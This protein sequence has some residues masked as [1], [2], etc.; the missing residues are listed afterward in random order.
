MTVLPAPR[1][2]FPL[3]QVSVNLVPTRYVSAFLGST[4]ETDEWRFG[5][6]HWRTNRKFCL[7]KRISPPY[8]LV[9]ILLLYFK[10]KLSKSIQYCR[11]FFSLREM[12]VNHAVFRFHLKKHRLIFA[13][14]ACKTFLVVQACSLSLSGCSWARTIVSLYNALTSWWSE[15]LS[16]K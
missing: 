15:H 2:I 16:M 14:N 12:F 11:T 3:A 6:E 4:V 8:C 5:V 10:G 13:W 9:S 7:G 1:K